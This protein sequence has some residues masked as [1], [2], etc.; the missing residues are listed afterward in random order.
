MRLASLVLAVVLVF[1][2]QVAGEEKEPSDPS[3]SKES[4][5]EA[6][7]IVTDE[8]QE[9]LTKWAGG[10]PRLTIRNIDIARR[11]EFITVIV[12]FLGCQEDESGL[13]NAAVDYVSYKPDGTVYGE[14]RDRELW[15]GKPAPEPGASQLSAEY[16]GLIIEA[17]DPAG[18][19]TV[20]AKVKDRVGDLSV[21][22]SRKLKVASPPSTA[23]A[24]PPN[25]S[26]ERTSGLA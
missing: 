21:T 14:M 13:C 3:C 24:T 6:C 10:E 2:A 20:E 19:Y 12:R 18:E 8:G 5:F 23:S 26:L 15:I 17:T 1:S 7:L 25:K 9:L 11:G 22:V 16:M 4:S